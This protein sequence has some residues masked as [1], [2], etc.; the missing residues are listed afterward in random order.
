[1][2][3]DVEGMLKRV[4]TEVLGD[5]CAPTYFSDPTYQ[6]DHRVRL[7]CANAEPRCAGLRATYEWFEVSIFDLGVSATLFDYGDDESEKE[8]ILRELALV[9]RAYLDGAG[10]VYQ[11]RGLRSHP[12]LTITVN[13]REWKLGRRS[14]LVHYP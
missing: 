13:G 5:D 11:K 2:A 3:I 4:V 8:A 7:R 10:R 12:V 14:S 9:A 6:Q 1:M